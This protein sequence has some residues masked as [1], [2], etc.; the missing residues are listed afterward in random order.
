M[1]LSL[2]CRGCGAYQLLHRGEWPAY[3]LSPAQQRQG[4]AGLHRDARLAQPALLP[5]SKRRPFT[6]QLQTVCRL[7]TQVDFQMSLPPL[8]EDD[9]AVVPMGCGSAAAAAA[10]VLSAVPLAVASVPADPASPAV[11]RADIFD[12]QPAALQ[13]AA[14]QAAASAVY[15]PQVCAPALVAH[16]GTSNTTTTMTPAVQAFLS[17]AACLHCN[18]GDFG[19]HLQP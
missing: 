17:A 15:P 8:E 14:C 12:A 7:R 16:P 6:R 11:I 18:F 4:P 2:A 1:P 13:D 10:A 5:G 19:H 3:S 9:S